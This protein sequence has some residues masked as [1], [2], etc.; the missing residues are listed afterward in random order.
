MADP[1]QPL[2]DS[3]PARPGE[4]SR[5]RGSLSVWAVPVVAAVVLG[6]AG[7]VLVWLWRWVDTLALVEQKDKATAH[8]DT[9]K[10]AASV[11]VAGG[12]VFAL[13]LTARRQRTQEEELQV[14]RDE[15]AQRDHAQAHAERVAEQTRLHAERVAASAEK[16]ATDRQITELFTKAVEQLGHEQAAVRLGGLYTLERLAQ[17]HVE[18]R[19][20]VVSVLCAYLRMPYLDPDEPSPTD[21]EQ[22]TGAELITTAQRRARRQE[23]EVRLTIQRLLRDHA[24]N[25]PKPGRPADATYWGSTNPAIDI[26]VDLTGAT[27]INLDLTRRRL[28][29]ST[30]FTTTTFA[31]SVR[32]GSATFTGSAEFNGATFAGSAG[33]DEATFTSGAAFD[34]VTFTGGAWFGGAT[35]AGSAEF[36]RAT[37][38]GTAR[39]NGVTFTGH[40]RF[41]R[42]IFTR[43]ARFDETTFT[44]GAGFDEATFIC[45]AGFDGVTFTGNAMFNKATFTGNAMFN[46]A[47]FIRVAGF[48]QVTFAGEVQLAGATIIGELQFAG[49]R[50]RSREGVWP[51]GWRV[52]APGEDGASGGDPD[53]WFML[54]KV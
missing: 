23:R 37:F 43:S 4:R 30:T 32:F 50:T 36:D 46:R 29:P 18:Q 16:D 1:E 24:H 44:R 38:T 45:G 5:L 8:L 34:G 26:D 27:L 11:L 15:L 52:G 31:G 14:R 22:V 17:D 13:Y 20:P 9:V 41:N 10:I 25:T 51:R 2:T 7:V 39:F 48:G 21:V 47:T 28:H 12:G 42:A 35:F 3:E 19:R 49:A 6:V 40:T 53:Q 33:F 54:E